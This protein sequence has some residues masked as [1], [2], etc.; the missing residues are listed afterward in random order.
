MIQEPYVLRKSP[1]EPDIIAPRIL[2]E[3]RWHGG[4]W[5]AQALNWGDD[6]Q[7]GPIYVRLMQASAWMAG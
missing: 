5:G 6:F 2:K 1:T 4:P 7:N 3:M